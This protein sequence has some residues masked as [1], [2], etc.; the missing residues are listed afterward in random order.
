[1]PK[2]IRLKESDLTRLIK[3]VIDEGFMDK[4]FGKPDIKDA[5]H[6]QLRGQGHSHMGKEDDGMYIVFN[7]NKYYEGDFEYADY[8]DTGNIPRVENG[9]L[10]LANPM[11]SN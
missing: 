3:K 4:L 9:K 8:N 1:M 7:G 10:I 5:Q 11:W 2:V 6:D